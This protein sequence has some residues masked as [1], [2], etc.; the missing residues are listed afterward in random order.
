MQALEKKAGYTLVEL[1]LSL[2]FIGIL[3]LMV[4]YLINDTIKS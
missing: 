1:S 2:V 4:A 3:S